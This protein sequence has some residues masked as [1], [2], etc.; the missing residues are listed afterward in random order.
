ME[1][2]DYPFKDFDRTDLKQQSKVIC[3]AI[4]NFARLVGLF[5]TIIASG[6]DQGSSASLKVAKI[7]KMR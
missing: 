3:T 6:D 5:C 4:D 7:L 2:T 1:A